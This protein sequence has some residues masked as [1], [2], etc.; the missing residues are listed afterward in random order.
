MLIPLPGPREKEEKEAGKGLH[1]ICPF[2]PTRDQS[3][4]S[5]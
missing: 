1:R 4:L 5:F 3:G 2:Q